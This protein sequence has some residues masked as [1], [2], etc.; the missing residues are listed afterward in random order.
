[1]LIV[2]GAGAP[3]AAVGSPV[4]PAAAGLSALSASGAGS[5]PGLH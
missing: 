1:V 4:Q 5:S 2:A 3:V